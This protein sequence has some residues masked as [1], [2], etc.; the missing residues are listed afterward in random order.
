MR[1]NKLYPA[2][3]LLTATIISLLG[4]VSCVATAPPPTA[5]PV[6][7]VTALPT[8]TDRIQLWEDGS[9]YLLGINY[10]WLNYGHDFGQAAW[11][12]GFW[13]HDGVSHPASKQQVDSHFA[14]LKSKGVYVVR[15][16]LFADGRASPE[17]DEQGAVTGFDNHFYDDLD[18][19]LSLACK[20]DLRLIIVLL[21]YLWLDNPQSVNGVQLGGHADVITDPVKRQSFFDNALKPLFQRYGN[22]R[23]IIA[24]EVMNEPE[25]TMSGVPGGGTVGPTVSITEMQSFAREVV[26]YTHRY[27]DQAVTV[28]SAQGQWLTY[29]QGIGLDF[30]QFHYYDQMGN[31]P[32]FVPYSSLSLDRPAI[33]GEFPT[34]SSAIT[35]TRY[36][37]TTWDNGYAGA[38]AW[39]LNGD[40]NSSDFSTP[41]PADEFQRW[42]QAH[43]SEVN[44]PALC[45]VY[46]PA[47]LR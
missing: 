39:S 19:A 8:G 20:H 2:A 9:R 40:D 38:L 41:G 18:T 25:W 22:D 30:Y 42:S 5:M 12:A 6:M 46:L 3:S 14:Y 1:I 16:F 35:V 21:D 28:G 45:A 33:L 17:F 7:A 27:A 13:S 47:V 15:L 23:R 43:A 44:I 34:K 11:P 10:P 31:Q 36:L 26:N 24:W 32:P 4:L 29:W 37:S